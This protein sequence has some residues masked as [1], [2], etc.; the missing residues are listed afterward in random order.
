MPRASPDPIDRA[1]MSVPVLHG[2]GRLRTEQGTL[3]RR[4][5]HAGSAIG[6]VRLR[7]LVDG[8]LVVGAIG[9]KGGQLA[10]DLAQECGDSRGIP[11]LAGRKLCDQNVAGLA[12]HGDR[13]L[14]PCTA[15]GRHTGVSYVDLE[16]TAVDQ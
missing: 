11:G 6:A 9:T 2:G 5:D 16:T 4:D 14:A 8:L 3:L 10:F 13:Y 15:F 12:I 7:G 1:N